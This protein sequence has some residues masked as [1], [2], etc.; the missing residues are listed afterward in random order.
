MHDEDEPNTNL[1]ADQN[2]PISSEPLTLDIDIA[3]EKEEL[4][5]AED[6]D[7]DDNS[8]QINVR[9]SKNTKNL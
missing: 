2:K 7:S 4:K 6:P 1:L 5:E 9:F 8:E 3:M